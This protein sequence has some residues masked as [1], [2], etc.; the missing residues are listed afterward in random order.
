MSNLIAYNYNYNYYIIQTFVNILY[1]L[2]YSTNLDIHI[3]IELIKKKQIIQN[4]PAIIKS[5]LL[6]LNLNYKY[7]L[8]F[9]LIFRVT[10]LMKL[11][12]R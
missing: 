8:F 9:L 10:I 2:N 7:I 11:D 5:H 4:N 3:I 1:S 12:Y 6:I